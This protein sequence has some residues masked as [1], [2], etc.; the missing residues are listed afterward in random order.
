[1]LLRYFIRASPFRCSGRNRDKLVA[2]MIDGA[3]SAAAR[4]SCDPVKENAPRLTRERYRSK[5]CNADS[6]GSCGRQID[7]AST[8][9][10]SAIGNADSNAAAGLAIGDADVGA[11]RQ[12]PM[13]GSESGWI[14]ALAAGGSL[15]GIAIALT[16]D[17][18]YSGFCVGA[19]DQRK[20]NRSACG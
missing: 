12:C 10:R 16:V 3:A 4:S 9:E 6:A 14:H 17:G 15:A 1:M 13:G 7:H 20:T 19:S 11:K 8:N 18:R 5:A 2:R